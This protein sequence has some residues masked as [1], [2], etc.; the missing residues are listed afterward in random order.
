[1]AVNYKEVSPQVKF[2]QSNEKLAQVGSLQWSGVKAILA[3]FGQADLPLP[4]ISADGAKSFVAK[5][6]AE[7]QA[8]LAELESATD[9]VE[10]LAAQA[11]LAAL[12][13]SATAGIFGV[14]TDIASAN[15]PVLWQWVLKHP[16]ILD[17]IITA[18]SNLSKE[19]AESLS[20]ADFMR[21]ARAAW[22]RIIADGFFQEVGGFFAGL[23]GIR[24]A[25][26]KTTKA[27]HAKQAA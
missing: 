4:N 21:V 3:A 26:S 18:T 19:D 10:S 12:N 8:A 9:A 13:Q 20:A 6:Q 11:K 27:N 25:T 24:P 2:G 5:A 15:L 17:A 23:L 1:M 22:G 16:P 14:A 7:C